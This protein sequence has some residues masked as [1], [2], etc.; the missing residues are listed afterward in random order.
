MSECLVIFFAFAAN[1]S[2]H[3]A[4][5]II[6]GDSLFPFFLFF[7]RVSCKTNRAYFAG[8]FF[9]AIRL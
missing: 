8:V 2:L 6:F 9:L 7:H 1:S 4:S 5:G 3:G